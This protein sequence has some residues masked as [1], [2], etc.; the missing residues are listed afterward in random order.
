MIGL[1]RRARVVWS[2]S[3]LCL[4]AAVFEASLF[5]ADVVQAQPSGTER[6][7]AR[8]LVGEG[9]RLFAA[10]DYA[11]A[12]ARYS[13]AYRL[14]RAP[15]VGIE[16]AKAQAALGR[17]NE[18][19]AK[20]ARARWRRHARRHWMA[21]SPV[22]GEPSGAMLVFTR[23]ALRETGPFD[24]GYHLYFEETDWLARSRRAGFRVVYAPSAKAT[25]LYAQSSARE[26]A[27]ADWL[28]ASAQRFRR[29]HY[30]PAWSALLRLAERGPAL[31]QI[32][33]R[34]P[35][36]GPRTRAGEYYYEV[37]PEP[38]GFPA[39]AE[40][41]SGEPSEWRLP[42]QVRNH[43]GAPSLAVRIV[44]SAGRELE[45]YRWCEEE[46]PVESTANERPTASEVKTG[47]G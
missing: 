38:A 46:G 3:C 32:L 18:H 8:A 14:V 19:W 44:D 17:R 6:E 1:A 2:V 45:G 23:R 29:R 26:A 30:G 37:T 12:L 35:K 24:E 13:S 28:A 16:V 42:A 5:H 43:P 39:A 27:A 40:L 25:H 10:K 11:N 41:W 34:W 22:A 33:P 47:G 4:T 31:A 21:T 15:T 7:T 20:R 36:T 9:D